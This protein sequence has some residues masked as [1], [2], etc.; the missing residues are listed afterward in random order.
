MLA[1]VSHRPA[2]A[3]PPTA[4]A[5]DIKPNPVTPGNF[6]GYGFDQCLAPEQ[7]QMNRWLQS[8]PFLAVGIYISGASRGC[9]DQPN[10][11]PRWIR[12]QL[13]NGW[14]LL[15]ITLGPQASCHPDFPRYGNDPTINPKPGRSNRYSRARKQGAAE[16]DTT[17]AAATRLGLTKRSTLWYDL[18][19]FNANITSCRESALYFLSAWTRR[20]HDLGW[21]SG[22][23]SS[24]GSGIKML[25]DARV[26][27]PGTFTLPDKIWVARWDGVANTS[28]SYIREDGWRPG[29]RVKQ[30]LGGHDERWGG[31]RINID[32]N[33]LD[34]GKTVAPAEKHCG[35]VRVNFTAYKGLEPASSTYT[36]SPLLVSA[37]KCLLKERKA[38]DGALNGRYTPR[39]VEA[40]H[41]WQVGHGFAASD[42]W[43]R[44]HWM[45][46]LSAGVSPVLKY[47]SAGKAVRRVQRS[48]N[49]ASK[50]SQLSVT[51][52]FDAA[53]SAAL[54]AWQSK[55]DLEVSGVAGNQTWAALKRGVR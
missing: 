3:A 25:D 12:T 49:A 29:G 34:L 50:K 42:R 19:G 20:L 44:K 33:Y 6:T 9:R 32:R 21:V 41:A 45:T 28:T 30:Y 24:A 40:V 18:E 27:R 51:G 54:R 31:V 48:L 52:I 38:Y 43:S 5:T 39:L 2:A 35:G 15:P 4:A 17:V 26:E 11:T 37:L 36:P 47:G 8:S 16:A 46:L 53:T 10:L 13:R 55:H 14:R 7:W 22:V 1:V 23:Y